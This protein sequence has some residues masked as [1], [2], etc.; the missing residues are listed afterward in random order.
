MDGL[1]EAI[2]NFKGGVICESPMFSPGSLA[3]TPAA[4]SHDE[5]FIRS[6]S[7]QLWVTAEGTVTKFLG[8]VD[9]YKSLILDSIRAKTKP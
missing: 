8:D 3:E 2:N 1:I 9:S 5:R 7:S 6:T 4:I